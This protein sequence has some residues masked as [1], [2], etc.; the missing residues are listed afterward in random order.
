MSARA[1]SHG[2]HK[3][4]QAQ[5]KHTG[6]VGRHPAS[7]GIAVRA[8]TVK[9]S[10]ARGPKSWRTVRLVCRKQRQRTRA[11]GRG[12]Q[13]RGGRGGPAHE[14]DAVMSHE[15]LGR[16][17]RLRSILACRQ[18]NHC[19]AALALR[20]TNCDLTG[21]SSLG[22]RVE[23]LTCAA[24]HPSLA[25]RSPPTTAWPKRAACIWSR[26][27]RETREMEKRSENGRAAAERDNEK[28]RREVRSPN[29]LRWQLETWGNAR[30]PG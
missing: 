29:H 5:S 8:A 12:A 4:R 3:T 22:R 24:A 13:K 7:G 6:A 21:Y 19:D 1:R 15:V 25:D 11:C 18:H 26:R 16:Q 14:S 20:Q 2:A 30:E 23:W 17:L 27:R 28:R 9:R 10:T